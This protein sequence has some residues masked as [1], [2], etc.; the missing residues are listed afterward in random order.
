VLWLVSYPIDSEVAQ[1]G[2]YSLTE[3]GIGSP[4][5]VRVGAIVKEN[6]EVYNFS[7]YIWLVSTMFINLTKKNLTIHVTI[8][9]GILVFYYGF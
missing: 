5:H 8:D 7:A 3:E 9:H 2:K 6:K 4:K 1:K